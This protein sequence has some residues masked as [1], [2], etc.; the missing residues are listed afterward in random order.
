VSKHQQQAD[1]EIH[2][3]QLLKFLVNRLDEEV[4]LTLAN[5]AEIDAEDIYEVLVGATAD[6]TSISTLC[7][8]SEDSPSANTILYHLRTKFEPEWLER[9]ANTLLR[10]D[11]VELLP[12]RWRSA[13]TSTCGP[14][15]V[16]KTTQTL[17]ITRKRSVVPLRSTPTPQSTHV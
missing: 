9:V 7:N 8:S 11:I 10:R 12:S 5:N 1:S 16:T 6:G 13:Q 2:Q 4:P 14:T 17:S 3:D 15:T